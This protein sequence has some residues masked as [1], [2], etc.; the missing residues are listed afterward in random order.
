[1]LS[2]SV[3]HFL[4]HRAWEKL[5]SFGAG[6]ANVHQWRRKVVYGWWWTKGAGI[7][8]RQRDVGEK[9]MKA[10]VLG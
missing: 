1:M 3:C 2:T 4:L 5:A 9:E 8:R 7:G 10:G 6:E